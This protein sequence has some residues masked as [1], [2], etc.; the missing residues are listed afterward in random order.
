MGRILLIIAAVIAALILIGPLVGL[1]F[2][3][4]KWALIIGVVGLGVMLVKNAFGRSH[5]ES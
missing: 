2:T 3:L 4:L 1:V 5:S